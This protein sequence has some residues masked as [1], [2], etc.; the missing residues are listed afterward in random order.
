LSDV[1]QRSNNLDRY[2]VLCDNSLGG[3]E[4]P[5]A[6]CR[7]GNMKAVN[8]MAEALTEHPASARGAAAAKLYTTL[9]GTDVIKGVKDLLQQLQ[10]QQQPDAVRQAVYLLRVL[11]HMKAVPLPLQLL[12]LLW[13]LFFP[14]SAALRVQLSSDLQLL[15]DLGLISKVNNCSFTSADHF[16]KLHFC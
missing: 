6:R 2:E 10:Q 4:V 15:Q 1:K 9:E 13:R 11:Q 7:A 8:N 3:V 14:K 12:Q 16:C 5:H